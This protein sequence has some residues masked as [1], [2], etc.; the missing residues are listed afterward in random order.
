MGKTEA[1]AVWLTEDATSPYHYWQYWRNTEDADVS[2][3][4]R[5]FTEIPLDEIKRLEALQG[6]EINGVYGIAEF[7]RALT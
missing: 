3:F 7:S 1:G 4:L 2:R 5:L 6:E